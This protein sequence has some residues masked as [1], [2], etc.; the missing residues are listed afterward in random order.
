VPEDTPSRVFRFAQVNWITA[1]AD[2][3]AALAD[4]GAGTAVPRALAGVRHLRAW[5]VTAGV[6][7]LDAMLVG[8][9]LVNRRERRRERD[10]ALAALRSRNDLTPAAPRPRSFFEPARG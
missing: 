10:L 6:A 2:G 8:Y 9:W 4:E 7:F 5:C 3:W 1:F